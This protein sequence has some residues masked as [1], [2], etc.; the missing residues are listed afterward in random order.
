MGNI[1]QQNDGAMEVSLKFDCILD[2][3]FIRTKKNTYNCWKCIGIE[4][5][6]RNSLNNSEQVERRIQ[7]DVHNGNNE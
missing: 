5:V 1:V 4:D 7:N 6:H 3:C 2:F